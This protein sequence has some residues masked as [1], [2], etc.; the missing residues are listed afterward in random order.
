ML[1]MRRTEEIARRCIRDINV[2]AEG[3]TLLR[4]LSSEETKK[5]EKQ[6]KNRKMITLSNLLKFRLGEP[7]LEDK[8]PCPFSSQNCDRYGDHVITCKRVE[9]YTRHKA[10]V[11]LLT[12]FIKAAKLKVAVDGKISACRSF[13]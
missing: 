10:V 4:S 7:L 13:A 1:K 8:A 2:S 6:R 3:V 11:D 9:F 12:R 5:R